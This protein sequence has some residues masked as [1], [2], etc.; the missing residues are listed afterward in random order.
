MKIQQIKKIITMIYLL[1]KIQHHQNN[2]NKKILHHQK[3]KK[4]QKKTTTQTQKLIIIFKTNLNNKK[5][6]NKMTNQKFHLCPEKNGLFQNHYFK[7]MEQQI[8][9]QIFLQ[10][11]MEFTQFQNGGKNLKIVEQLMLGVIKFVLERH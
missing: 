2:N 4:I 6:N 7:E 1:Q 8:N 10:K 3:K 9:Q 5:K 11:F